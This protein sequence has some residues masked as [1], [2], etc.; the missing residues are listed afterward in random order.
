MKAKTESLG[1]KGQGVEALTIKAVDTAIEKYEKN[2]EARCKISPSE[3]AAKQ[4]LKEILHKNRDKLPLNEDGEHFY[5][6][7]GVD[8]ILEEKLK[9]TKADTEGAFPDMDKD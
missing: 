2:K 3:V 1:L 4:E 5:R 6:Y 8:Y 7:E 9:R